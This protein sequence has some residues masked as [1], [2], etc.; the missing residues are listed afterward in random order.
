MILLRVDLRDALPETAAY[1]QLKRR[2]NDAGFSQTIKAEDGTRFKLP[3]GEFRFGDDEAVT[4]DI[5]RGLALASLDAA[6]MK[7]GILV[8]R[9][10]EWQASRLKIKM[11]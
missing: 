8:V 9:V 5:V 10:S 3:R 11:A 4:L 7:T 6:G 2:L 1:E